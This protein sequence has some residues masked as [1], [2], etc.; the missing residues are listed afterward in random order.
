MPFDFRAMSK[1]AR[2]AIVVPDVHIEDIRSRAR[3][4]SLQIRARIL[5]AGIAACVVVAGASMAFGG[6]VY[7]GVRLWLNHGKVRVS[8]SSLVM[9]R[10]PMMPDVL[11]MTR[12][13]TFPIIYPVGIP[14]GSRIDM[15]LFAPQDHP[16]AVDISYHN[17]RAHF[18]VGFLVFD[19]SAVEATGT[20][21][22]GVSMSIAGGVYQWSVGRETVIVPKSHISSEDANRVRAAMMAAT[23]AGSLNGLMPMLRH[24]SVQD[25]ASALEQVAERYAPPSGQSVLLEPHELLQIPQLVRDAKPWLDQRTVYLSD[26]P[27]VHGE[28]DY[29]KAKLSWPKVP[30]I[31]VAGVRAIAAVLQATGPA[32][33]SC[34]ILFHQLSARTYWI[35]EIPVRPSAPVQRFSVDAK[36][37]TIT[38]TH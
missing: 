14:A 20:P 3:A 37:L 29:S 8:V 12:R 18:D 17:E 31:T 22:L 32:D 38:L 10:Y 26:I 36:T 19:S 16:N 2:E 13:A 28:P 23:P 7:Q 9:M 6:K 4:E 35:W 30:V 15:A 5:A 24:V 1:A 34:G 27:L 21:P 11:S 33:C 25:P